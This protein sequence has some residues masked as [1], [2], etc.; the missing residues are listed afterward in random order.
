MIFDSHVHI[1][2]SKIISNVSKKNE[3][4]SKLG[5]QT[6]SADERTTT[7]DLEKEI[8]NS[9]VDKCFMLPTAGVHEVQKVNETCIKI[10]AETDFLYTAGTLHP[11]YQDNEAELERLNAHDIRGIKLCSFSQGFVLNSDQTHRLFH[12][13]Q[14]KNNRT[15]HPFFVVL[16]TFYMADIYFGTNPEYNTTPKTLGE[17]VNRF[18]RINFIAA[19]MGGLTA[20]FYDICSHLLPSNN[21][22]LDT[23]NAAHTLSEDEFI[24]LLK[25]HGPGHIL[26]G[27]DWPWFTHTAEIKLIN[28][29]LG[30]AGYNTDEK[31]AVFGKNMS[32][33]LGIDRNE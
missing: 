20:P 19:H 17:L 6:D 5:L 9:P 16:D 28:R 12:L 31:E 7:H 13:V 23:S 25:T 21:L 30:L 15:N 24:H 11:D 26:F 27:T 33:L 2:S 4:I 10:A 3:M 14:E 32:M 22:F 18:P 8:K 29:L 1:F